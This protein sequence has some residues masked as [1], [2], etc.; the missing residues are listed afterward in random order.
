[1]DQDFESLR[2]ALEGLPEAEQK[3]Q[4]L[5]AL[6]RLDKKLQRA[7]FQL[8]RLNADKQILNKLLTRTSVDL[9]AAVEGAQ[10]ASRA[11]SAFL[12]NMSHELRTPL[13]A[14]VGYTEL[15]L[16]NIYGQLTEVQTDRLTRVKTNAHHLLGIISDILDLSKI[17]AGRL[18]I[19]PEATPLEP[20]LAEVMLAA[21]PLAAKNNNQLVTDYPPEMGEMLVDPVRLKQILLNLLSNACKFTKNGQVTLKFSRQEEQ[22]QFSVADTGIGMNAAQVQHIFEE[23]SQADGSTTK[24]YG[25]TGLGLAITKKLCQM[26]GGGIEVQSQ[27]GQG[28]LFSVRLPQRF[29]KPVVYSD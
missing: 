12:A 29:T 7:D 23:F 2:R 18:D 6:A 22:I 17:E 9:S 13:G 1:M 28:S 10:A 26:M 3:K 5:A 24:L 21:R 14:I 20:L 19:H 4:A 27:E 15:L 11:K 25:G 8:T 16:S